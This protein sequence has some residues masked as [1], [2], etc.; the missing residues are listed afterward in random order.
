MNTSPYYKDWTT[1]YLLSRYEY[2]SK[3][4]LQLTAGRLLHELMIRGYTK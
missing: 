1:D 3:K 4:K 2:A